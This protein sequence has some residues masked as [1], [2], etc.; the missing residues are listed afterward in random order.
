MTAMH[1]PRKRFGQHFLH[2]KA[3]IERIVSALAPKETDHL[4]EIGPGQGAITLPVL[5]QAK[6]LEVIELDRDLIPGLTARCERSG[7]LIVYSEDVLDFDFSRLKKDARLLRVFGN[8]PYNISSPL[9]FHLIEYASQISDMLFMLQKEVAERLAA[10]AGTDHYG[11]LSVMV[12]YHC[13]VDLLFNVP[14]NAFYP[15][16]QVQS[17]IVRLKPYREYPYPAKDYALFENVVRQA[18]GQRRKT[19]RNSLK[20]LIDNG[21]WASIPVHS[22][23]R[24]EELSVKDFVAISNAIK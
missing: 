10:G 5:R 23:L 1:S 16:P 12:Q 3:M 8:L 21:A 24:P 20:K 18:F 7:D 15:P 9:I 13:Q 14:P 4:V 6:K 11:R 19:L 17:S 2:D 22:D